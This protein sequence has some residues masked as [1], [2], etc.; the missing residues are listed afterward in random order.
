[1]PE[2]SRSAI[3]LP[4]TGSVSSFADQTNLT[5]TAVYGTIYQNPDTGHAQDFDSFAE[6]E[7]FPTQEA[8]SYFT[9]AWNRMWYTIKY[10]PEHSSL[11]IPL[12]F[13]EHFWKEG[14]VYTVYTGE[15]HYRNWQFH[16]PT[17]ASD[18]EAE[19]LCTAKGLIAKNQRCYQRAVLELQVDPN[20]SV[21]AHYVRPYQIIEQQTLFDKETFSLAVGDEVWFLFDSFGL[22]PGSSPIQLANTFSA[23]VVFTQHPV[24]AVE[25]MTA[26][27]ATTLKPKKFYYA[28]RATDSAGNITIGDLFPAKTPMP[29][30]AKLEETEETF[31]EIVTNLLKTPSITFISPLGEALDQAMSTMMVIAEAEEKPPFLEEVDKLYEALYN[32]NTLD[33]ESSDWVWETVDWHQ[34]KL[35]IESISP[36]LENITQRECNLDKSLT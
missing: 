15:I 29:P 28:M 17:P 8:G 3:I 23:P 30:C 35:G 5:L 6:L 20:N 36:I 33:L 9:Y 14:T 2:T 1:L 19:I 26:V 10:S 31:K 34:V 13:S 25:M 32:K 4:L 7:V 11:W 27:S 12:R 21:V 16:Y 22:T 24:F 18:E